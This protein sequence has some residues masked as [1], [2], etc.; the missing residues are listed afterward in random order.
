ME[1]PPEHALPS[2]G[3]SQLALDT[4]A[5]GGAL[6]RKVDE[7]EA[8]EPAVQPNPS[9][10]RD[11]GNE[12]SAEALSDPAPQAPANVGDLPEGLSTLRE[13]ADYLGSRVNDSPSLDEDED[14][15]GDGDENN[16]DWDAGEFLRKNTIQER[17]SGPTLAGKA[18][19]RMGPV[20]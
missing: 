2:I 11:S 16:G 20:S 18:L 4:R 17:S 8:S 1:G 10:V 12:P 3:S 5:V 15:D 14:G 7:D 6:K 9:A 13:V 19:G